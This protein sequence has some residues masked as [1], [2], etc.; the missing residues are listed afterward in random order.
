MPA[1]VR[2]RIPVSRAPQPREARM[3][4]TWRLAKPR[5]IA[6]ALAV[7][8]AQNSGGW[9]VAGASED[10]GRKE[11]VA[12]TIAGR[13]VVLWRNGEGALVAGPGACPQFGAL[14]DR[15]TV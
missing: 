8:Q 11:S 10:V 4:A 3:S 2:A 6:A 5:R 9:Y 15:C 7:A 1:A 12:R 13:E 14:L